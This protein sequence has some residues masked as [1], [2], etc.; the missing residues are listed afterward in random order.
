MSKSGTERYSWTALSCY[1]ALSTSDWHR[2]SH[3]IGC[4]CYVS[5]GESELADL[6]LAACWRGINLRLYLEGCIAFVWFLR[7]YISVED[8]QS[9]N[10]SETYLC[11]Q[12]TF[13]PKP[14]DLLLTLSKQVHIQRVEEATF[15]AWWKHCCQQQFQD[16]SVR[17]TVQYISAVSTYLSSSKSPMNNDRLKTRV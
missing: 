16:M 9:D 6:W 1:V 2:V 10:F 8:C 15:H 5:C 13:R 4:T 7:T 14:H 3:P 17:L 12:K 11:S